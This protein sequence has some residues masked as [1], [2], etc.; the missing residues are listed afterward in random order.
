ME[1]SLYRATLGMRCYP[2]PFWRHAL[3]I[4][5]VT[6]LT[7][8]LCWWFLPDQGPQHWRCSYS[9]ECLGWWGDS[10]DR[11]AQGFANGGGRLPIQQGG[12]YGSLIGTDLNALLQMLVVPYSFVVCWKS[13]LLLMWLYTPDKWTEELLS[14]Q[15][16]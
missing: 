12:E 7:W 10:T 2:S 11:S 1:S 6:S 8:P 14:A 15:F 13:C 9:S 16:Y 4:V 3:P 5:A